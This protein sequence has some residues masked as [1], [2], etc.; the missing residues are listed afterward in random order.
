VSEEQVEVGNG[1]GGV[2]IAI[3]LC[4]LDEVGDCGA[5][6]VLGVG[7]AR[8]RPEGVGCGLTPVVVVTAERT[9]SVL[10]RMG[11]ARLERATSCL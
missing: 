10:V 8:G 4:E 2:N 11:G 5:G 1:D 6:A 3:G 9:A 7:V